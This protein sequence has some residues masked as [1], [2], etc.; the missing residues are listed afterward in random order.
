M[1]GQEY[2]ILRGF[3]LKGGEKKKGNFRFPFS[4]YSSFLFFRGFVSLGF[5][6]LTTM[7][8]LSLS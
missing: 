6:T 7:S 4:A 5:T 1:K 2:G 3:E 8:F